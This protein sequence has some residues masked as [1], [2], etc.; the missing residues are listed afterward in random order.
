MKIIIIIIKVYYL[1][2]SSVFCQYH[3]LEK[4]GFAI[5]IKIKKGKGFQRKI[6]RN[7]LFFL[8]QNSENLYIL[9][10]RIFVSHKNKKTKLF[11]FYFFLLVN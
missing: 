2:V 5:A 9:Y 7:I 4:N 8:I 10:L 3:N 11:F 6:L 1:N